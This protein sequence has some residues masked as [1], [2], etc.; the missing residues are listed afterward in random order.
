MSFLKSY[1][2]AFRGLPREVWT[3]A[4]A[5]LINRCGTMVLP[6]L[7]IYL[8]RELGASASR[9]GLAL[10]LYGA[11]SMVGI[12]LGAR[13]TDRW[14]PKGVQ[15]VSLVAS[16]VTLFALGTAS[17]EVPL[18]ALIT[19]A[20]VVMEAFRPASMAA[21]AVYAG[22]EIRT[23]SYGLQRLAINAGMTVGPALG[24]LLATVDFAYLFWIDGATCLVA[25]VFLGFALPAAP[26]T[27]A[28]PEAEDP[29]RTSE[30][31]AAARSSRGPLH[32]PLFLLV[33]LLLL[34][35]ALIFQQLMSTMPLFLSAER[36]LS[37]PVIGV[38]FA[39]NTIAIIVAEMQIAH[40]VERKHPLR[41]VGLAGLL[42]GLGFGLLPWA[43]SLAAIVGTILI[44]TVGE[45]LMGPVIA[46]WVAGRA[47]NT[48]RGRYM[49]LFTLLFSIAAVVGPLAG[50]YIMEGFGSTALWS[51]CLA[52]G[53]VDCV[54]LLSV[55]RRVPAQALAG[56]R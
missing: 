16:G 12:L 46:G 44:W 6:F 31:A 17:S 21:V 2:R 25:A 32:D 52:I 55:A 45:M 36:G 3:L 37:E 8:T 15:V 42:I 24:G 53:A 41:V 14:S 48:H 1:Q 19:L 33:L 34:P 47:G 5:M 26:R 38:L 27:S 7:A 28:E 30:P 35:Q 56:T 13:L 23:R 20:G 54:L 18:F 40:A 10:A 9:A 11:G 43:T 51:A 50:T 4:G 49:G 39:S 29:D 22:P